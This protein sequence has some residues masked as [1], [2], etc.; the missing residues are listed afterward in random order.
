MIASTLLLRDD[1]TEFSHNHLGRYM[2]AKELLVDLRDALKGVTQPTVQVDALNK[3]LDNWE[4]SAAETQTQTEAQHTRELEQW[5]AQLAASS[6][7]SIEMFKAV[8]EAG[9]TA[10][11]SSIVINGGAAAA[12]LA[13][14]AEGL[15]SNGA[16]QW[17][18]L[19]SPLGTAWLMFML[20]LGC[21][22]IATAF[23]YL[24]QA[25]YSN[26]LSL[27]E[28]TDGKWYRFG[29]LVRNIAATLGF[30]S[31]GLFFAGAVRIFLVMQ[32]RGG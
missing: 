7:T 30:L 8:I 3:Y 23:R 15:K 20:G 18:A 26:A 4:K 12:L 6:A 29:S 19:L 2:D 10:L 16:G 9:Q 1:S 31:Y 11:K 21:A 28:R 25:L 22:G 5:K 13:L 14:L 17:G 24:S 27:G 32:S